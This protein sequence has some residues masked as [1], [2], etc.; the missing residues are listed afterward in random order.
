MFAL[1]ASRPLLISPW[2]KKCWP[3]GLYLILFIC[4]VLL[5]QQQKLDRIKELLQNKHS[6]EALR[7][8]TEVS[9]Q[10]KNDV[11]VHL[12][13]GVVL[14]S[15]EQY[16]TAALE[17]EKADVLQPKSFEIL[18]NL[19]LVYFRSHAYPQ[20]E[21]V[22]H[23]ALDIQPD[24]PQAL[25]LQ[26]EV[27]ARE[28]RPMDGL[29]LL[30]RAHQL[31]PQDADI[32]LLMAQISIAQHYFEDAVPLLEAGVAIAPQRTDLRAA[33]A[34][35]YLMSDRLD[36]AVGEWRKVVQAEPSA[37]AYAS[38]GLSY[39]RLGRF[40]EAKQAFAEGLARDPHNIACLFH[41]GIVAQRQGDAVIAETRLQEVLRLDPSF[42]DALL[43][44]ANLRI[45]AKRFA[46]AAVL[47]RKY[48]KISRNPATGYYKLSMVERNLHETASADRDLNTFQTLSKNITRGEYPNE[49]LFDYLGNRSR[50]D[51]Q[52]GAEM[53]I[54]EITAQLK[55]HPDQPEGLYLLAEAYLK[56]GK[57]DEAKAT[58]AALDKV[59]A[60]DYRRLAGIGVLLARYHLY[61][62]AI[63]H[64]QAALAVNAGSDDVN[65]DLADAYFRKRLYPQALDALG[66]VSEQGRKDD[67]YLA[68]LGDIYVHTGET[69]RAAAIF[70][71]A[72]RRNPDNDQD[73]L[74]LALDELRQKDVAGAKQTLL[75]GQTRVPGSGKILWGLG[76][77]AALEGNTAVAG[78]QFERAVDMLPEWPGSYSTLGVF[79]FETGRIERAREVLDRFKNSQERGALDINRIEQVLAHA[80]A[81]APAADEP[82]PPAKRAQ[83]L[84]LALMLADRTL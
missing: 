33:L 3:F 26:G 61:D 4:P 56:T 68:L 8:A 16:K 31:A 77:V 13:L 66:Q 40:D 30:V 76:L 83:L 17:L 81:V 2:P 11:H 69:A 52:A 70:H 72:I 23:R 51:S 73:Y 79:Y 48:V 82:L 46:E 44:I 29:A 74:A 84:Q 7:M 41:L 1:P 27:L 54:S 19:G 50:L 80:P 58:I 20:A 36:K 42:A 6:A 63:E 21:L 22:L 18:Y 39:F 35:S 9:Q 34:E 62:D 78:E 53:D 75:V 14:A 67:D 60:N 25:S 12:S 24:S 57:V 55:D 37:R 64:F 65:F 49:H 28:S 43:G 15:A 10:Y 45:N 47:L 59:S 32:I 5:G 38:L 71:D